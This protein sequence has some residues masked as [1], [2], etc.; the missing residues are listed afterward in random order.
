MFRY[1]N[2]TTFQMNMYTLIVFI[3]IFMFTTMAT[4]NH[5]KPKYSSKSPDKHVEEFRRLHI[6]ANAPYLLKS[7]PADASACQLQWWNC[8]VDCQLSEE[9]W[10]CYAF[11]NISLIMCNNA[12]AAVMKN[13]TVSSK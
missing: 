7:L 6:L 10:K 13:N 4:P 9:N 3:Y 8:F 2:Q 11:C 12:A 5:T 1:I